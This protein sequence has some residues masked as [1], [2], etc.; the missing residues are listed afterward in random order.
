MV[1]L[2]ET[3]ALRAV[4]NV[5]VED[6]IVP[7][8]YMSA[9]IDSDGKIVNS[10]RQFIDMEIFNANRDEVLLDFVA[11][12]EHTLKVSDEI[13]AKNKEKNVK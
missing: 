10:G 4:S 11:F 8:A 6:N 9:D 1:T 12:D 3:R 13:R 2:N 5:E 7:V